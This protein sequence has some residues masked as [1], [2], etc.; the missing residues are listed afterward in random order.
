MRKLII[1]K[2]NEMLLQSDYYADYLHDCGEYQRTRHSEIISSLERAND[3]ILLS[4][5][6]KLSQ[7]IDVVPC[8]IDKD[9]SYA[10]VYI[11]RGYGGMDSQGNIHT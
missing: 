2:I 8:S 7:G 3:K 5:Y 11:N 10:D 4:F 9:G 1:A 6:T